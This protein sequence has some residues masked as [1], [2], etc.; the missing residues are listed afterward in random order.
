MKKLDVTFDGITDTTGFLFSFAKCLAAAVK[1][2]QYSELAEDIIATSGFA[3]RMWVAPDLCPSAMSMWAFNQ[4]KPWVE[5]GGL[6]CDYVERLWGQDDIEEERRLA[7]IEIIKESVDHGVAAISW[8]ISGCEWGLITGYDEDLQIFSTLKINNCEDSVPYEKLGKIELPLLSV[9][10]ITGRSDK[11]SGDI[12]KDTI[13]L[14]AFHLNGNEWCDN[15]KGLAAYS[16]LINFIRDKFVLEASWNLDYYLGTYAALKWYA[17]RYFDKY[18]AF[19]LAM[20]YKSI[21]ES[22][23][24]A[25]EIK[26]S[27]DMAD[28]S[29]KD[30]IIELLTF[31]HKMETEAARFGSR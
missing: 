9:L 15:A 19:E 10:T 14:A 25:F 31:A 27:K 3:F 7:A 20:L 8:D 29:V 30:K 18:G 23:Q 22:W 2:S 12:I 26:T 13:N 11:S 21:Y 28:E 16:E 5:N 24:E 17:W 4:Q 1:N 6:V